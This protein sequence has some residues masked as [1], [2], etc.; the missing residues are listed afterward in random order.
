[1]VY[2]FF[3]CFFCRSDGNEGRVARA[4]RLAGIW[5]KAAVQVTHL[6]TRPPAAIGRQA[7]YKNA[8]FRM[9]LRLQPG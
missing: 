2:F 6:P 1:M 7:T 8:A 4:G 9:R 3:R 5:V